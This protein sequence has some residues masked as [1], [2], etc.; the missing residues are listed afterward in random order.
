MH[1]DFS[2]PHHRAV[3]DGRG[4]RREGGCHAAHQTR[5]KL[6][7][8]D[9]CDRGSVLD[10][11]QRVAVGDRDGQTGKRNQPGHQ[12]DHLLLNYASVGCL[13]LMG[14]VLLFFATAV[15]NLLRSTEPAEATWSS[16][17]HGG[18]VVTAAGLSQMVTWNWGLI[19]GA[20]AAS[21]DAALKSLS[22]VHFFGWAGDGDRARHGLH[23][24]GLGW[25][26]RCSA[27]AVVRDR[28]RRLRSAGAPRE[29]RHPPGG[30]VNFVLL[31]FWLIGASVIMARRQRLTTRSPKHQA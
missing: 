21:D 22:Y 26:C 3:G 10:R 30:L 8:L 20:A 9:G 6:P 24:D 28:N 2:W 27:T 7:A 29:R 23:R 15:R 13:V 18:W 25:P 16:I 11:A 14:I 12:R 1:L 17:A 19:I 31:P 5:E 4:R